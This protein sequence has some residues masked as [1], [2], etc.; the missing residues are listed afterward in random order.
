[1]VIPCNRLARNTVD[2]GHYDFGSCDT[3]PET[4]YILFPLRHVFSCLA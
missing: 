4:L 3:S 2:L 1:M